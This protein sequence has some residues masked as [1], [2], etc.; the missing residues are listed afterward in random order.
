MPDEANE[1]RA[2]FGLHFRHQIVRHGGEGTDDF[3]QGRDG[4]QSRKL[5]GLV[6]TI[7][8][9]REMKAGTPLTSSLILGPEPQPMGQCFHLN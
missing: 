4:D 8:Q 7:R 6:S 9:Q 2:C 3:R 1:G 5:A